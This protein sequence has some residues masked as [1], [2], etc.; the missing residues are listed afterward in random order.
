MKTNSSWVECP[1]CNQLQKGDRFRPQMKCEREECGTE[2]CFLHSGAHPGTT[3]AE[4]IQK[5]KQLFKTDRKFLNVNTIN[6]PNCTCGVPIAKSEGCNHMT[7][8]QCNTEFCYLC[9]GAYMDGLHY[10]SWN[11]ILGCPDMK[12]SAESGVKSRATPKLM[13]ARAICWPLTWA[14]CLCPLFLFIGLWA[15]FFSLWLCILVVCSPCIA[16]FFYKRPF[17]GEARKWCCAGPLSGVILCWLTGETF[18]CGFNPFWRCC[19]CK[20][21]WW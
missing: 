21:D 20:T 19:Q 16:Y 2:F 12:M 7:C 6:C 1:R 13:I 17:S 3:C 11:K 14:V 8:S 10:A 15:A 5:N 9:G 4:Y 18:C